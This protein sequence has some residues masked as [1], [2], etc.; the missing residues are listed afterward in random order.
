MENLQLLAFCK[1][2]SKIP[3]EVFD[4]FYL[5]L[6]NRMMNTALMYGWGR[7]IMSVINHLSGS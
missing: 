6:T 4:S 5:F 2:P 1:T 7:I 3:S